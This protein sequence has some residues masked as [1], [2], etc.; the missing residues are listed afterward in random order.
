MKFTLAFFSWMVAAHAAYSIFPQIADGGPR[1]Q[2]WQT[3]MTF[4]NYA[5]SYPIVIQ[6]NLYGANGQ[7]LALDFGSGPVSSFVVTLP[8]LG[9]A[10]FRTV[11]ANSGLVTG[12]AVA[13][14]NDTFVG[15]MMYEYS[16]NGVPAQ[17]V[18]VGA[19]G[20][21]NVITAPATAQTGLALV[22]PNNYT[23]EGVVVAIDGG[24][25]I[26]GATA[27]NLTPGQHVSVAL[28]QLVSGIPAGFRG[29]VWIMTVVPGTLTL[30]SDQVDALAISGDGGVLSSYPMTAAPE[31]GHIYIPNMVRRRANLGAAE[32]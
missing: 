31:P 8:T 3:T 6:V 14:S 4:V 1:A 19:I 9:S 7:S 22:N 28:T 27:G 13:S 16:V 20:S 17:G 15:T 11:G 18:T 23:I 12:W 30:S 25:N 26:V 5:A 10:A 2:N 24:G 21:S 32:N 29:T